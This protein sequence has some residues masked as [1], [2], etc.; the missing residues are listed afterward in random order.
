MRIDGSTEFIAHLNPSAR[1]N[2]VIDI[3]TAFIRLT[4][5][6]NPAF[7][8]SEDFRGIFEVK[9]SQ[10]KSI[11]YFRGCLAYSMVHN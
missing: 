9:E 7:R 1:K 4:W 3:S 2:N 5:S 6:E 11:T 8:S 10:S